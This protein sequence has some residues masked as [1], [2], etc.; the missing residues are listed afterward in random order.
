MSKFPRKI[1]KP[2]GPAKATEGINAYRKKYQGQTKSCTIGAD[3]IMAMAEHFKKNPKQTALNIKLALREN[4]S[5][6]MIFYPVYE[7]GNLG[8]FDNGYQLK[9]GEEGGAVGENF[10]QQ[11]P[12]FGCPCD[13]SDP[14]CQD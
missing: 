2:I 6:D 10:T 13:P 4:E 8:S 1:C 7:N 3:D 14:T 11:C 9:A 5:I 12:P